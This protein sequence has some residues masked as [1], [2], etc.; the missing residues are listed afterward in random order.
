[1]TIQQLPR[2]PIGHSRVDG[3]GCKPLHSKCLNRPKRVHGANKVPGHPNSIV[4]LYDR[5]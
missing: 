4:E 2:F 5:T 3:P 1:M